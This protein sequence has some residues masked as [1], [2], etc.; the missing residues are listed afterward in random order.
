MASSPDP[1]PLIDRVY[2]LEAIRSQ[3]LSD[4]V[5]LLTLLGPGGIGKTRLALAAAENL[6]AAFADGVRFVDLGSV[7]GADGLGSAIAHSLQLREAREQSRWKQ[8]LPHLSG[9][10]LLLVLD[11]F[12]HLVA[13]APRVAAILAACPRV[14]I[15]ATSREP[16]NL[17]LEYRMLLTGLPLPE[18]RGLDPAAVANAASAALF[19]A[20]ARRVRPDLVL[21]P[22]EMRALA[23]LLH[24]LDGVPLA[25]KIAASC[26]HALSPSAM[27]SRLQGQALL[28]AEEA[29]DVPHRHHTLREAIEWSDRLLRPADQA[30]FRQLGVFAGSW[31]LEAAE[32]VVQQVDPKTPLLRWLGVLVDKS[33]VQS[34]AAGGDGLRY[35]MLEAVRQYVIEQ[36]R[37]HGELAALRQRHAAFYLT[38]AERPAV[39]LWGPQ[40]SV[41]ARRLGEETD[42][43]RA[44]LQWSAEQEDPGLSLRLSAALVEYWLS[45]GRLREGR[46]WLDKA[47]AGLTPGAPA[48]RAGAL[49]GAATL[50]LAQGDAPAALTRLQECQVLLDA[51]RE[52]ALTAAVLARRGM[53]AELRGE[54]AEAQ[55][56]LE[57]SLGLSRVAEDAR[58]AAI[59]LVH[60][61]R[62]GFVRRDLDGAEA[63]LGEGLSLYRKIGNQRAVAFTLSNLA[64]VKLKQGDCSAAAELAA[65]SLQS[66]HSADHRRVV[67]SAAAIAACVGAQRGHASQAAR[68]LAGLEAWGE[69]ASD[70]VGLA[71]RQPE[72]PATIARNTCDVDAPE[73]VSMSLQ[74]VVELA[75]SCLQVGNGGDEERP[76][77]G[78]AAQPRSLLS[79]REQAVVRL[80][81]EGMPN[82]QIAA[83]LRIGERTVKGHIS[84]AM[85]KLGVDNRAHAAVA[86]LQRGLLATSP[87]GDHQ[88]GFPIHPAH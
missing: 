53:L 62:V 13:A 20:H 69:S 11:N 83:A 60:L 54:Y 1:I 33:L 84:S 2:E 79:Q 32:A 10:H 18:L 80:I 28:T 75:R 6:Q 76:V 14:K 40:E 81:S 15:L 27:L 9:R 4:S 42:N 73:A 5:R 31:T 49:L 74:D 37:A 46:S 21:G 86:A 48:L 52:P 36:M 56:L 39:G 29:R 63:A 38:L 87:M 71:F 68:L 12:E 19:L 82:K 35:R 41:W 22:K 3:L 77:S 58:E 85:N 67:A 57:Q 50:A 78:G 47:L 51:L 23:E 55:A 45:Q 64:Q 72:A 59:A 26:S 44:A 88:P 24:R 7:Q 17:R 66:A 61:A 70:V 43:L 30:G 34:G 16:L 8:V 65:E 25:I